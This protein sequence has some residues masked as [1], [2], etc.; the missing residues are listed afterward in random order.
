MKCNEL[1][2]KKPVHNNIEEIRVDLD[3]NLTRICSLFIMWFRKHINS[4][5]SQ[6]KMVTHPRVDLGKRYLTFKIEPWSCYYLA[7]RN[8][9]WEFYKPGMLLLFRTLHNNQ[10]LLINTFT[11]RL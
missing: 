8:N 1:T 6:Y 2:Q 4:T 11:T 5:K 9:V 7:R 3:W 10:F